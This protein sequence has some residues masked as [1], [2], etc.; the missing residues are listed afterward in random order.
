MAQ[1]PVVARL[2][3][4]EV[5]YEL[6][7]LETT[8][9]RNDDNDVVLKG[10]KSISGSHAKIAIHPRT[11]SVRACRKIRQPFVESDYMIRG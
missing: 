6:E 3:S 10:S 5:V 11:K 2:V 9:G 7:D 4:T 8:I 1:A